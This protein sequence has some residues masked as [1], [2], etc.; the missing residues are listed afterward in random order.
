MFR[1]LLFI[2]VISLITGSMLAADLTVKVLNSKKRQFGGVLGCKLTNTA[3]KEDLPTSTNDKSEV[4]F[5]KLA[6]GTYVFYTSKPGYIPALSKTIQMGSK[7]VEVRIILVEEK[8][9]REY[10]QAA[11]TAYQ[12]QNYSEANSQYAKAYEMAPFHTDLCYNY[13][14]TLVRA[15][16]AKKAA[17]IVKTLGEYSPDGQKLVN[18][19]M[20]FE[21]GRMALEAQDFKKAEAALT[22]AVLGDPE[23]AD[24]Y[25]GLALA[26]GHQ[27]RYV[28]AVK[29]ITLA[30]TL[31]PNDEQFQKVKQSIEYNA[32]MTGK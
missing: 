10:E 26:L 3:T 2:L 20:C 19:S 32:R 14:R 17:E 22:E 28:E 24:A 23:N 7:D 18:G 27:K 31:K 29:P 30:V 13:V 4:I 6:A 8:K 15:G 21:E 1:K 16:D 9:F 12:Q 25:Y 11:N 5:E